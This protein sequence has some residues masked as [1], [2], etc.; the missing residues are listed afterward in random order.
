MTRERRCFGLVVV[1]EN[2][3]AFGGITGEDSSVERLASPTAEW[4]EIRGSLPFMAGVLAVV[5]GDEPPKQ[6]VLH[7]TER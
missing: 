6:S 2:L 5:P 4:E 7:P 1:G 3:Y